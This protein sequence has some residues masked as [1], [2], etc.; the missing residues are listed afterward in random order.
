MSLVQAST[1]QEGADGLR[2]D[3]LPS[4]SVQDGPGFSTCLPTLLAYAS[5]T[6]LS[7]A[8]GGRLYHSSS[9]N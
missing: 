4:R 8:A 2:R 3:A 6:P 1:L 9:V 7:E 5:E